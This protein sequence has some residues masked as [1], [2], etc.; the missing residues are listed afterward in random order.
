M[1]RFAVHHIPVRFHSNPPT[2]A[3]ARQAKDQPLS[4]HHLC[5]SAATGMTIADRIRRRGSIAKKFVR[6]LLSKRASL[7]GKFP[8]HEVDNVQ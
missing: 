5:C 4:E 2:T 6:S 8:D 7:S 1:L 3:R